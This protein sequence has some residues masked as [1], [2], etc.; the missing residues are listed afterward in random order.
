MSERVFEQAAGRDSYALGGGSGSPPPK[1]LHAFPADPSIRLSHAF[2]RITYIERETV[3]TK[4]KL[5]EPA[6]C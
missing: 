4:N 5:I 6:C 2:R 1:L 3:E